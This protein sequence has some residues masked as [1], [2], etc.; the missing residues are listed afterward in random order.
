MKKYIISATLIALGVFSYGQVLAQHNDI[1]FGYEGGQLVFETGDMTHATSDARRLFEGSFPVTGVFERYT[2]DP[3]F[4][5]ELSEGL[6]IGANDTIGI[7][8]LQSGNFGSYLTFFDPNLNAITAT[9]ATIT[10]EKGA[11]SLGINHNAGGL[12]TISQA[13]GMG[14]FH[15]H[16]DFFLSD[17]A[18]FGAYGL[19]FNMTTDNAGIA[20]SDP[21]W[22]VF[23][24]GMDEAT[25]DSV[26]LPVFGK[27]SAIPEPSSA[28]LIGALGLG[29]ASARRKRKA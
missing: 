5:S 17:G 26:A 23:N 25:F 15:D 2:D 20:S 24:Y 21:V 16:I 7:D 22:L 14:D 13:D 11:T 18:A 19:L 9:N 1:E 8:V 29:L 28:L 6:G 10:L 12:F 3:G 27:L 4:A